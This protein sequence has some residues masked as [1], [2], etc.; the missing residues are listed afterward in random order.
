MSDDE[1]IRMANEAGWD[2]VN[3]DDGFGTRLKRFTEL[4]RRT[5]EPV[6]QPEPLPLADW[7]EQGNYNHEDVTRAA[8]ELR[9]LHAERD[10]A[11]ADAVQEG[12]MRMKLVD[13]L[14]RVIRRADKAEED[15]DEL[16]AEV[17]RLRADHAT[18][19]DNASIEVRRLRAESNK[20]EAEVERLRAELARRTTLNPAKEMLG[21]TPKEPK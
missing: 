8:A 16:R 1:I 17:E 20:M 2:A 10:E 19:L 5:T 12:A 4:A 14:L 13:D 11:R 18:L 15:L 21:W 9:R 3:L 7:L 6:N